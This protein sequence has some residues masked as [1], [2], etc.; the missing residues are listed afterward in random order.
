MAPSLAGLERGPDEEGI[1]TCH[2]Q[3]VNKIFHTLERGPDEEGIETGATEVTTSRTVLERG[4][5]EE[6]IET[7]A[8]RR[9]SRRGRG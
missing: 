1:E 2:Q 6:G 9:K 8:A 4:P 5:D 7:Q 3:G